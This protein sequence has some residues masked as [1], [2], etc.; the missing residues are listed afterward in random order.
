MINNFQTPID[1]DITVNVNNVEIRYI[2]LMEITQGGPVVGSLIINNRPLLG[3][4]FGGPAICQSNSLYI[5]LYSKKFMGWG[6]KLVNIDLNNL[7]I[8]FLG[9]IKNLIFLDKIEND[10]IYFFE[11][12]NKVK[13]NYYEI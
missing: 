5:P 13:S 9:R 6:F 7:D 1:F 12:I 2:D 10:R 8:K 4:R 3:H 11:D